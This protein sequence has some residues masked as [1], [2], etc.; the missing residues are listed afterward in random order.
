MAM[1][2]SLVNGDSVQHAAV[3]AEGKHPRETR[4]RA[5][6]G[7][8]YELYETGQDSALVGVTARRVLD[9]LW[10]EQISFKGRPDALIIEDLYSSSAA[11]VA[12]D[13]N[14]EYRESPL[15]VMV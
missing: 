11:L 15:L 10:L 4:V 2:I 5:H 3:L 1:I 7:A 12:K 8:R 9:E 14:G 13:S 6:S